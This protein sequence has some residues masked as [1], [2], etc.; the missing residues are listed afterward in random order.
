MDF[1][2][3]EDHRMLADLLGRYLGE[4]YP[5]ETR[6][7]AAYGKT[8]YSEDHWSALAE[9]GIIGALFEEKAG[10]F[11]GHGPEIMIVFE[12][13]GRALAVEPLLGAVM[14][15]RTLAM[16]GRVEELAGI[17]SGTQ[18]PALAHQ[19]RYGDAI[20]AIMTQAVAADGGWHLHGAKTV[21]AQAERATIFQVS[22]QTES[23]TSLFL[24]PADSP[25]LSVRGYQN[26]EGGRSGDLLLDGVRC[27]ADSLIGAAGDAALLLGAAIDGGLLALTA[28]ALGIMDVLKDMTAEYLR[29][30]VQFGQKIGTFQALQHRIATL[31]IEI[32]QARSSVI[33]AAEML[34][35][36][37]ATARAQALSAAKY[38]VGYAGTLVAEEAIQLHGGIGM[39]W[40]L[41][42]S[43]YAKRLVMIDH[44][45]GNQDYHLAQYARAMRA[46]LD[47]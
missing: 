24:V 9:L 16:S 6:N 21:V 41:P 47:G 42:L 30:R 3:R 13:M 27:P 43:H 20:E 7:E 35:S 46:Q 10:G 22:A 29:T 1:V 39:T 15:G 12:Q 37:D 2:Q 17:I 26:I 18:I 38:T 33:N 25:G 8:G 34:D 28:E 19:E 31:S 32:E 14:V 5:M 44:L 45:L 40:E 23:G 36:G 11:G 4:R